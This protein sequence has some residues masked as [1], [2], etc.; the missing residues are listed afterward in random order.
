M[1]SHSS[2]DHSQITASAHAESRY[3][4]L[5]C[6]SARFRPMHAVPARPQRPEQAHQA[7]RS[8]CELTE[9]TS[10]TMQVHDDTTQRHAGDTFTWTEQHTT[11]TAGAQVPYLSPGLS[12][13]CEVSLITGTHAGTGASCASI[14]FCWRDNILDKIR[15][16]RNLQ[17]PL[18]MYC[19]ICLENNFDE[20]L[21]HT[22]SLQSKY[23]PKKPTKSASRRN[24]A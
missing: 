5:S 9:G 7:T 16:N 12:G 10:E 21:F 18:M 22:F 23:S 13:S 3:T 14:A 15:S 8:P 4:C 19:H 24:C 2:V 11:Q 1:G 6:T 17:A 20:I